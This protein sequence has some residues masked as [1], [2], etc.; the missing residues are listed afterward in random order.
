MI[1][2]NIVCLKCDEITEHELDA[3]TKNVR[4]WVCKACQET[5]FE[6]KDY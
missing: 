3:E 4:V 1:T 5:I 2:A 6:S